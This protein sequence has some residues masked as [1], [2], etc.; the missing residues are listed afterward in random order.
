MK[1]VLIVFAIAA[2]LLVIAIVVFCVKTANTPPTAQSSSSATKEDTP[3]S[4]TLSGSDED[5]DQLIYSV[6][7]Q[8][9]HGQLSGKAPELTYN[10]DANFHG[11]DS[12]TFKVNDGEID[13][14]AATVAITIEPVNDSPKANDDNVKAR[15]DAAIATVKV[16]ANDT[17]PDGDKL[18]VVDA[19]QGAN[20][21]VTIGADSTLAYVPGRNFSGTDAFTY[22]L[23][24]GQGGTDTA[25]VSVTIDPINDVPS[26]TSKPSKTTRVWASYTYDVEAKDPD[27]GDTLVY[28][29]AKEP[30]GMTIDEN[31]G[32]IEW[33]PTS[34]QAGTFDITVKV[35]D[36]NS[37]RAWDTQSFTLTVASLSS[38]LT[39]TLTVADCFNQKGRDTLSARDR[40]AAVGTSDDDRM[41]TEARS[42]TCYR[43]SNPSIPAGAAI[44]SVIVYVEHF[45]QESFREERLQWNIGTGWPDKPVVWAS[46]NTPVRRGANNEATDSWDV[47]SSVDTPEKANSL[48]LQIKNDDTGNRDTLIDSIYAVVKWY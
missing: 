20:G 10:P 36:S 4:I 14:A 30:E 46:T 40:I 18:M 15:E 16:L 41:E 39:T 9:A 47:T 45:E 38:P 21:S 29:L 24:D 42:Y 12:F 27:P 1:R 22:T 3:N 6:V 19:T 5:A 8:P 34:A 11:S 33:R 2:V 32:L 25:T 28:S 43:F 48:Q 23:S 26:I 44:V 13:S 37:I 7:T 17:D 31:T 35:A